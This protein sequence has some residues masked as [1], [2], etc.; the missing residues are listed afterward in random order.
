MATYLATNEQ[1]SGSPP[2][3]AFY[4]PMLLPGYRDEDAAVTTTQQ[5]NRSVGHWGKGYRAK[6]AYLFLEWLQSGR[7]Q[8]R[9]LNAIS[10]PCSR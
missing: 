9:T 10:V 8:S 4:S 5:A 1:K 3:R 2:K 7:L 6:R